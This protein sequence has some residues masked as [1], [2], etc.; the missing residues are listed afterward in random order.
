MNLVNTQ[1]GADLRKAG[2]VSE[3]R[4]TEYA[5]EVHQTVICR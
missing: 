1:G 4:S 5:S 3:A 2:S